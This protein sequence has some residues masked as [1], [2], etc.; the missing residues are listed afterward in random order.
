MAKLL[1]NGKGD[2]GISPLQSID[3][4]AV[5]LSYILLGLSTPG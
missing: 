3:Y 2:D 1:Q 4:K 5:R